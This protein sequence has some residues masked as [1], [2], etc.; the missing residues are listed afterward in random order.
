VVAAAV[1]SHLE[2]LKGAVLHSGAYDLA[3]LYRETSSAWLRRLLNP[4]GEA[5]P[6]LHNL[7]PEVASWRAPTLI[8]H[9]QKDALIP[10][11]QAK[12][13]SDRLEKL[14]KPHQLVVFAERGH[15]FSMGEVKE[16]VFNFLKTNGGAACLAAPERSLRD[17]APPATH[18]VTGP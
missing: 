14:G 11:S 13:L 6:A 2:G 16:P 10:V 3:K 5:Q 8:L 7:L 18:P 4:N 9:G 12:L 17:H 15:V 1:V